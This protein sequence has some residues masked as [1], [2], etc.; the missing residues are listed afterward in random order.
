M[1]IFFLFKFFKESTKIE[2]DD[3]L[4]K[5]LFEDFDE[6]EV[7]NGSGSSNGKK[8]EEDNKLVVDDE[9]NDEIDA[10]LENDK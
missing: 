8:I 5:D 1:A 6:F 2:Q 9:L 3:S 4:E 7:V 10:L